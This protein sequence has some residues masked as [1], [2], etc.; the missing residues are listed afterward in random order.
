MIDV[1]N[2]MIKLLMLLGVSLLSISNAQ[3]S[4]TEQ[5][6]HEA[7]IGIWQGMPEHP[8]KESLSGEFSIE[9]KGT[10]VIAAIGNHRAQTNIENNQFTLSFDSPEGLLGKFKAYQDQSRNI[11]GHWLQYNLSRRTNT[12][13]ATPVRFTRNGNQ[14]SGK[15]SPL[16]DNLNVYFKTTIISK[17]RYTL[18]VFVPEHNGGRYF[19]NSELRFSGDRAVIVRTDAEN[20]EQVL[21][22]GLFDEKNQ[23]ISFHFPYW[24]GL[25]HF[26]KIDAEN[27]FLTPSNS[28]RTY[29]IPEKIVGDWEVGHA[30]DLGVD[31]QALIEFTNERIAKP[32]E[33]AREVQLEA[34]LIARKGKLVFEQYFRGFKQNEPHDLRSASKSLTGLLPGLV[35]FAQ[36]NKAYQ[37][38]LRPNRGNILKRPIYETLGYKANVVSKKAILLEH[39]LNMNTGLDCDDDDQASPGNEN[40]MQSQQTQNDWQTYILDQIHIHPAGQH[41][42][43]CSGGINLGGAVVSAATGYWVPRIVDDLFARPLGINHY[44]INLQADGKKAYKGGGMQLTARDF[45]K[46]GQLL[47]NNG[48]WNKQQILSPSYIKKVFTEQSEINGGKY[49]LGWWHSDYQVGDK[50][51]TTHYAS[52]NGGQHVFIVPELDLAVVFLSSSFNTRGSRVARNEWFPERILS[53][54]MAL[55]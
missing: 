34:L 42:A 53:Q 30:D 47:L 43:Y 12:S 20:K 9:I 10:A 37:N 29:Q 39:A 25:Y 40:T 17:D 46:M 11:H 18:A 13:Y 27:H 1:F 28:K 41:A 54:I 14:Y 7:S 48:I 3:A 19:H 4:I 15:L 55:P 5:H 50:T 51:Y 52:G 26:K 16:S 32:A 31:S 44:H 33:N 38:Q 6:K 8:V 23:T 36:S 24:G 45:L 49:G 21:A 2:V 35:E 22:N